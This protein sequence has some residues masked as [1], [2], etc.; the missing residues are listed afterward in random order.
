MVHHVFRTNV[1]K[2]K[3]LEFEEN[4]RSNPYTHMRI[5]LIE[6]NQKKNKNKNEDDHITFNT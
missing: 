1:K 3:T 2:Y 5:I 4:T 6:T